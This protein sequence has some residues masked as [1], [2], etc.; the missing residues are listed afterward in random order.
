MRRYA[1]PPQWF[2]FIS[3][4]DHL[5]EG[6]NNAWILTTES[7]GRTSSEDSA[8]LIPNEWICGNIAQFLRLPIPPFALMRR[9]VG[10]GMFASLRFGVGD[11]PPDDVRPDVCVQKHAHLCTG[12]LL[13]DILIANSDRH[14]G[15]IKVDSPYDPKEIFIFDH[16]RAL[17]GPIK[18]GGRSRLTK[19]RDRLGVS[20]GS[21]SGGN[22]HCFIDHLNTAEYFGEWADRIRHIPDW[23]IDDIC[24]GVIRAGLRKSLAD[25]GADFIK[26]RKRRIG[27]IVM[28][29]KREFPLIANWGL[30]I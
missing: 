30:I 9:R 20:A 24:N 29:H 14:R 21:V 4:M 27:E 19:L 18:G 3:K 7:V 11:T 26:H 8:Y 2:G 13:F 1:M 10:K 28:S 15:N 5:S 22:P 25:A 16:D 17:F 23:F 12:V 6:V